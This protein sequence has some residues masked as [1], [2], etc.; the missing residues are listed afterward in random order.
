MIHD[1][2]NLKGYQSILCLNGELPEQAFFTA[3][4]L[5]VIAA[6]GAANSLLARGV[7]PTLITGDLD[8]VHPEI[9]KDHAFLHAP[10]QERNDYQ[11]AMSYLKE[12]ELLPAIVVGI[13]GGHLDHILN[14]INIF[15]ETNC[16]LYSPPIRG[17]VLKER[18]QANLSLPLQTKI[19]LMGI[20]EV[21]VSSKG[22]KWELNDT[23]LSFP[24]KTSCFN[25]TL[26][27]EITI[28]V[29]QGTALVL[30]YEQM[31][32]DAGSVT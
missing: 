11:K 24:G 3:I 7:H 27:S 23:Q 32:E 19:S 25:R 8:S 29:H 15:M 28:E 31:I 20:P 16:L 21:T 17:F 18:A 6:D 1:L 30:I 14:N 4:N 12:N 22:L 9:L 26:S 13:S 10:D 2:I 5:P